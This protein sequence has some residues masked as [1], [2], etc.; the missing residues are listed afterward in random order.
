M[1][2]SISGHHI[3]IS[4]ALRAAVND[5]LSHLVKYDHEITNIDV[6]LTVE[7]ERQKASAT[8]NI[9]HTSLHADVT[10]DD[11]YESIDKLAA[12][13]KLQISEHKKKHNDQRKQKHAEKRS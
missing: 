4:D 9:P 3:E 7:K 10:T 5:K 6:I 8:V 2:I 1:D 12:K 11:M 13:L